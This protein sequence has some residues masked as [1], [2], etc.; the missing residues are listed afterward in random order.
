MKMIGAIPD[1]EE[2]MKSCPCCGKPVFSA[3]GG[4]QIDGEEIAGYWYRWSEGH[5]GRFE[6]ALAWGDEEGYVATAWGRASLEGIQY[7]I[8]EVADSPWGDMS[9]YGRHLGRAELLILDAAKARFFEFADLIAAHEPN[10]SK[11]I[12]SCYGLV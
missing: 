3:C 9:D 8:N 5:E 6:I 1:D 11:R 10:L 7:G 4:L 2:V 12:K